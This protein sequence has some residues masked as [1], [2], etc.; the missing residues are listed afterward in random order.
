VI[1]LSNNCSYLYLHPS[2]LHFLPFQNIIL[3]KEEYFLSIRHTKDSS[4]G[5]ITPPCHVFCHRHTSIC[6]VHQHCVSSLLQ[7]AWYSQFERHKRSSLSATRSR[8]NCEATA[9]TRHEATI[10]SYFSCHAE[11]IEMVVLI[12]KLYAVMQQ[13]S[14]ITKLSQSDYVNSIVTKRLRIWS[15]CIFKKWLSCLTA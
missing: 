14:P 12:L 9:L 1:T 11:G 4:K 5:K 15:I 6:T 13:L 2:T 7:V 8:S 3:P 10:I